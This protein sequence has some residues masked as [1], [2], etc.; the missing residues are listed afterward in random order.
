MINFQVPLYREKLLPVKA[1]VLLTDP[2]RAVNIF[3]IP[4]GE[5]H[6]AADPCS[7]YLL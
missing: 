6:K 1:D 2:E 5:R 3:S 4:P 7:F